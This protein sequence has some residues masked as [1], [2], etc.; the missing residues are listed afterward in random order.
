LKRASA[1]VDQRLKSQSSSC[2]LVSWVGVVQNGLSLLGTICK[3]RL[4]IFV[5]FVGD[6]GRC[7]QR[8]I[9]RSRTTDGERADGN[10]CRHLHDGE[11]RVH[12][13]ESLGLDRHAE[14]RQ[15]RFGGGHAR[16]MRRT[17]CPR[18]DDLKATPRSRFSKLKEQVGCTMRRN[19]F[20]FIWNLQLI[21]SLGG[22]FH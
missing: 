16:Q 4:T 17:A 9:D 6:D 1:P 15:M 22:M 21:E 14:H 2:S 10:A 12:A 5:V 3:Q 18:N 13:V 19:D 7:Q 8:R 20:Y 11:E